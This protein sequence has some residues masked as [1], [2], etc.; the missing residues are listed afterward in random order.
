MQHIGSQVLSSGHG[1][2]ECSKNIIQLHFLVNYWNK[3]S[4]KKNIKYCDNEHLKLQTYSV[5]QTHGK[6]VERFPCR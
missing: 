5:E 6:N 2:V 3:I 4:Y 1:L